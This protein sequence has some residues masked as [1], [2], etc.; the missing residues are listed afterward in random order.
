MLCKPSSKGDCLNT[1]LTLV[2]NLVHLSVRHAVNSRADWTNLSTNLMAAA[3][4]LSVPGCPDRLQLFQERLSAKMCTQQSQKV[5]WE[6]I[7]R[8]FQTTVA[9]EPTFVAFLEHLQT[10]VRGLPC[11]SFKFL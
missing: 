5:I 9:V 6:M 1:G 2:V 10:Y 4:D 11:H 7:N 8:L 3:F